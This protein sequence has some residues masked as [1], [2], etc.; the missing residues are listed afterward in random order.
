MQN[1]LSSIS[2][3]IV[4]IAIIAVLLLL[5]IIPLLLRRKTT[6][7]QEIPDLGSL[8]DYTAEIDEEPSGWRERFTN[9]SLAGKILLVIVPM[10]VIVSLVIMILFVFPPEPQV[11][12]EPTPLPPAITITQA[13]VV[14]ENTISITADTTLSNGTGVQAQVLEGD[15]VFPWYDPDTAQ[16]TV[17]NGQIEINLRRLENAPQAASGTT[18]TVV[19]ADVS[20]Q[21]SHNAPLSV[22]S[23]YADAFYGAQP[24]AE[25]PTATPTSSVAASP[26]STPAS[27]TPTVT[28]TSA[29]TA[30]VFN[31]GN[32]RREPVIT[33]DNVL[34]QINAGETVELS[35][36][37]PDGQWYRI[38]TIR[39]EEGW[40]SVTLLT[41]DQAVIDQVPVRGASAAST[42]TPTPTV[43]ATVGTATTVVTP[44]AGLTATVFNGGN[45]RREPVIT[46]DN[47]VDQ[48]HARETVILLSK[49]ADGNWFL[50][51]TE[52]NTEGWV[53]RSLLTIAPD[54][55]E[56]VPVA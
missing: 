14:N 52:R 4:I 40:V 33:S 24:T 42:A 9:L 3:A 15:Q 37:T 25:Q 41:I 31:G 34:A 30:T 23:L 39:D 38:K 5:I 54:V 21:V 51:R 2:P 56:R 16:T 53:S 28:A 26:T 45:V 18:Y 20:G 46:P 7:D 22:P 17:S 27:A 36:K 35:E 29:L 8:R 49:T 19:L 1:A 47:V 10:L 12:T 50:V 55:A 32:V 48:I 43:A 11:T 6:A 13:D 44:G